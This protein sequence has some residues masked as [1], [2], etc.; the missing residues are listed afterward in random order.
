MVLQMKWAVKEVNTLSMNSQVQ[1]AWNRGEWNRTVKV[2]LS[3][4]KCNNGFTF[5][6]FVQR[7][8]SWQCQPLKINTMNHK[9]LIVLALFSLMIISCEKEN[10]IPKTGDECTSAETITNSSSAQAD[11]QLL[12]KLWDEIYAMSGSSNCQRANEWGITPIGSKPCGGPWSYLAYRLSIDVEC[13]LKKVNY[14]NE[15]QKKYNVKYSIVSNC[16]VEPM[17]KAV[18]CEEGKPVFIY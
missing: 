17:P 10:T 1:S 8:I 16:M 11:M 4:C 14:Y 3:L 7:L 6:N 2:I 9:N 12:N 15:Q 5:F 13:F 18:S